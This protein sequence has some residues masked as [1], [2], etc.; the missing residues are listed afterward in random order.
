MGEVWGTDPI[1]L[2]KCSAEDWA[3]RMACARVIADD[4]ERQKKEAEASRRKR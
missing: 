1:E 4:R 2:M 3:I